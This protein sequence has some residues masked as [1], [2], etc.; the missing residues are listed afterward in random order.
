M[1]RFR[2]ELATPSDDADL[3]HVLAATPMEGR[4]RV[5]FRREPSWFRAARVDGDGQQVVACRDTESGRI[6][7][8]GSRSFRQ[9]YVDRE[10]GRVG[11]LSSL[12]L[13]AEYRN[14]GLIARGYAYFRRLHRDG[15]VPYYLT[16]IAAGNTKA[17][18]TL[19]AGRAG[20]PNYVPIGLYHTLAI[21]L[22]SRRQ[23]LNDCI[24]VRRAN[25]ADLPALV[26]WFQSQGPERQ[27]FPVV[28]SETFSE[29]SPFL[30]MRLA[31]VWIAWRGAELVGTLAAWDQHAYKQ[32]I[33]EGYQGAL[34]YFR[35]ALNA[36]WSWRGQPQ[37][38]AP[39]E[40]LRFCSAALTVVKDNSSSVLDALLGAVT[41]ELRTTSD[42]DYLLL[43]LHERD[44][45]L[46][47]V[48][49]WSTACYTTHVYLVSWN[50]PQEL[51]EIGARRVPYL[52]LGTL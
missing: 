32:N 21:P 4:V 50:D 45:L 22:A 11:Y 40:E 49:R 12:R 43:G 25:M 51:R 5:S 15:A 36:W 7:G 9:L 31:D 1:S 2:F 14:R 23:S 13:L 52:E 10:P 46:P 47:L 17:I 6:I 39:G 19:T 34:A 3:R 29:A 28:N 37:L 27:F 8:F 33:V 42:G 35:P 44:P 30:G 26:E 16:T 41:H 20:L 48:Q 18:Q 38:P 24:D